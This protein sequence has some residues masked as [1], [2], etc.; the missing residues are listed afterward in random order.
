MSERKI[1]TVVLG[2]GNEGHLLLEAASESKHFR[3]QAVA[4]KD[5]GLAEKLGGEYGCEWYD[6]YRHVISAMDAR[7]EDGEERCLMVGEGLYSCEEYVRLAMKKGFN[8]LKAAPGGRDFEESAELVRLAEEEGVKFGIA[9][10]RRYAKSFATLHDYIKTG[11]VDEIF[12][13]V[14]FFCYAGVERAGW[15]K[16][17]K[18]AGGGVLVHNSF[19]MID[20]IMWNFP[21]PQQVYSLTTNNAVDKQQRLSLTEDTAVV[22]MKFSDRLVG[23]VVVSSRSSVWPRQE[24]VKVCGKDR[25]LVVNDKRLTMRDGNSEIMEE[26][27]FETNS[28]ESMAGAVGDFG[29]SLLFPDESELQSSGRENLKNMAVIESAYLS[30]RTGMPE[31]PGKVLQMGQIDAA[32][33]DSGD[34]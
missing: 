32:D 16:D 15:Q 14:G 24:F 22:A 5:G 21:I 26:I 6:D 3:I 11:V 28:V 7:L 27:D 31:S 34:F 33:I 13:V 4:D 9:N 30:A 25:I 10:P 19:G 18:L 29:L 1:E 8:V 17:P 23:N 2:L 12:L 20:Q